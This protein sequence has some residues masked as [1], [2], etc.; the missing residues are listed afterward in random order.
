M[1]QFAWYPRHMPGGGATDENSANMA[2]ILLSIVLCIGTA[3]PGSQ[4]GPR[5]GKGT[6][7]VTRHVLATHGPFEWLQA[8]FTHPPFWG[9]LCHVASR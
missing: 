9:G 8:C 6:R 3:R 4:H 5:H 1:V 2:W 7:T